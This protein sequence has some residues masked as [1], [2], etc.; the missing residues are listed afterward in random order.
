MDYQLSRAGTMP[1]MTSQ[2]SAANIGIHDGDREKAYIRQQYKAEAQQVAQHLQGVHHQHKL[3]HMQRNYPDTVT[4]LNVV[5]Q[6]V[7]L[8]VS[9]PIAQQN[10]NYSSTHSFVC[11]KEE[12]FK[13]T[14]NSYISNEHSINERKR[15]YNRDVGRKAVVNSV[16]ALYSFTPL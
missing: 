7:P 8:Q 3:A 11:M 16:S 15:Y 4:R 10:K 12:E 1:R 6:H 14:R 2:F 9:Q 13:A 5:Q